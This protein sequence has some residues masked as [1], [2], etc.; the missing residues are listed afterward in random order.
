MA[1]LPSV[2]LPTPF[3][4]EISL[5][6]LGGPPVSFP[7]P[8]NGRNSKVIAH[9]LGQDLAQLVDYIPW[10]GTVIADILDDMHQ[11]E[12]VKLLSPEEFQQFV[13]YNKVMPSS[14]ALARA[15]LF[16]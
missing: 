1:F 14:V 11:A 8:P 2:K 7:Q 13:K 16:K 3:G 12:I 10:V 4:G 6:A 5:P 9:G 15:V